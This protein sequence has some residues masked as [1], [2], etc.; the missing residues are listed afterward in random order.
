[1]L[2]STLIFI[3]VKHICIGIFIM[4]WFDEENI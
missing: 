4:K 1:M 2:I 3:F